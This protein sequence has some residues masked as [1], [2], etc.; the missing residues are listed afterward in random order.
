MLDFFLKKKS[1]KG[2]FGDNWGIESGLA[3]KWFLRS[4]CWNPQMWYLFGS[5]RLPLLFVDAC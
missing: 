5:S 2:N 3:I 1:Y 4:F